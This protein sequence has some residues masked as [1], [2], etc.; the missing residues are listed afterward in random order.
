MHKKQ[1]NSN[2]H[3]YKASSTNVTWSVNF[4]NVIKAY[5]PL[6]CN[7][8]NAPWLLTD[9]QF[10]WT[11]NGHSQLS[12]AELGQVLI[13]TCSVPLVQMGERKQ[14]S[15]FDLDLWPM[16]LTYNPSQAKVNVDPHAK[17]QGQR[18]NGSN[19]RAP[20]DKWTLPN[21][22]SPLLRGRWV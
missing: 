18:S 14:F 5:Q 13:S 22:L 9:R 7:T 8:L 4:I 12:L 3:K 19:R 6:T 10:Q 2:T 16:T 1:Q 17:N 11:G 20:T 15:L 21:I